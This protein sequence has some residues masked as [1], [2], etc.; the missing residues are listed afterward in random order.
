MVIS[1]RYDDKNDLLKMSLDGSYSI[2]VSSQRKRG[3]G[4]KSDVTVMSKVGAAF[5][6]RVREVARSTSVCEE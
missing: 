4:V 6:A 5:K 1:F 2:A 3:A